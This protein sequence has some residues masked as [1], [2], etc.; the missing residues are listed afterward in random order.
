[1]FGGAGPRFERAV[2]LVESDHVAT[3]LALSDPGSAAGGV[4]AFGWYCAGRN[5]PTEADQEDR[6]GETLC[7]DPDPDTTFGEAKAVRRLAAARGWQRVVI[8]VSVDQATRAHMMVRRCFAG[9][10]EIV[11]V[12][13]TKNRF[14]RVGYEWAA[15]AY[16]AVAHRSC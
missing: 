13:T 16:Y 7:F 5:A 12:P 3:V 15:S 4:S 9:H 6:Y 11:T 14:L 8:V 10:I 2:G 1:M